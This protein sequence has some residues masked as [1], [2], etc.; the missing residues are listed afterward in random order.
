MPVIN[1]NYNDLMSL[2]G[3]DMPASEVLGI[4]PMMGA[5]LHEYDEA[6]GET[7][8]EFFPNRP[9]LYSVEGL[10]RALRAFLDI[11]PGL[12]EYP[13][14]DSGIVMKVEASVAGVRPFV[15]ASVVKGL[16][17]TDEGIRSLMELQEKLHVTVGRK[18]SKVAIGV[19]DLDKVT[20]P[21][22]YKAAAP[23]SISF[24]PLAKEER[25]DM[26]EI[27]AK[28]EKGKDY[29]HLLAGKPL[30]PIILDSNNEVLS[31]PPII[32]GALTAVTERTKNIFI[33]VTGTDATAVRGAL[34]IIT[35]SL[36]E[37]GGSIE[38]VTLKAEKK[39][40]TPDLSPT[41]WTLDPVQ[42][43]KTL[44][45]K[46]TPEQICQYLGRLG[47]GAEPGKKIKVRSP[48]VRMDLLH[49]ADLVEDV[50]IG[51]GYGNFG[52]SMPTAMTTGSELPEMRLADQV[53]QLMVGYSYYEVQTL[54]LSSL[55]EQFDG[56]RRPRS[57]AVEVLNP[58]S[59]D[60]DCLRVSL[61]PSLLAV[62]RKGKHRELPQRIFE[63]GDVV[64]D[65]RRRKHLACVAIHPRA[66]FT[67]C[68]SLAE[69]IMRE[70]GT[71]TT[72]RASPSSTYLAG[73]G[74]EIVW[75]EMAV[76]EFGELHP[77]IINS[78]ELM[79]PVIAFE[80]RLDLFTQERRSIV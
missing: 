59:E 17:F 80:V 36:A 48:A 13:I 40:V 63:V 55:R 39:M 4:I 15:V 19:H 34:N 49:T 37:R 72:I 61:L 35:T 42:V 5:D 73:R 25:M 77:E 31:F 41:R 38:S 14:A 26:D 64:V 23:S 53:R 7:S 54:T 43:N 11:S 32:N 79:A 56:L 68:K 28:H 60:T 74:A 47:H 50:A 33:D 46:A 2:V 6:S 52:H 51:Y 10:A 66:S 57:E 65:G 76:G 29:A 20:P 75:E 22:V 69:G 18:R 1:F 78:Y 27:L 67:E 44:G 12:R 70:L 16:D 30:Y 24:V 9:D 71:K 21:F 45:L 8:I 58:V 3:R 62:L